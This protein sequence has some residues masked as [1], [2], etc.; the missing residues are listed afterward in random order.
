MLKNFVVVAAEQ[1]AMV[2]M[3]ATEE[4][5][6]YH[7]MVAAV[8]QVGGLS[9]Q[10][11]AI[12]MKTA[13]E[14]VSYLLRMQSILRKK[15]EYTI[16]TT[17]NMSYSRKDLILLHKYKDEKYKQGLVDRIVS[18]AKTEA[19]KV[20]MAGETI[21]RITT[22]WASSRVEMAD[23]TKEEDLIRTQLIQIFHD[24]KIEV[25]KN[26]IS[27]ILYEYWEL[28]VKIDWS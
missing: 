17:I 4:D 16:F 8:E 20:A 25:L 19:L 10:R 21:V 12:L 2:A 5:V 1:Q 7:H 14:Y 11:I 3:V 28:I 13:I 6:V 18:Y 23:L 9:S 15:K 26:S 27:F 22:P 24:A